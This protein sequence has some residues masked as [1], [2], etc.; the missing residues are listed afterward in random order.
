MRSFPAKMNPTAVSR[1][2]WVFCCSL[3]PGSMG[4][5]MYMDSTSPW[6]PLVPCAFRLAISS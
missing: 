6:L 5:F 1:R 2:N 3:I 4:H